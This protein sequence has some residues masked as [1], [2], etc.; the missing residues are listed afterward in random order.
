MTK[1]VGQAEQALARRATVRSPS[2]EGGAGDGVERG[3]QLG[4]EED[5]RPGGSTKEGHGSIPWP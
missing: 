1:I 5:R 4:G 2:V 3:A